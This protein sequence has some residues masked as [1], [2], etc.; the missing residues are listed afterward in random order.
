MSAPPSDS[1][2]PLSSCLELLGCYTPPLNPFQVTPDASVA[3][4]KLPDPSTGDQLAV[5]RASEALSDQVMMNLG[6][7]TRLS[8]HTFLFPAC[9]IS[10]SVQRLMALAYQ[11]L[12]EA[13]ASTDQW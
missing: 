6:P 3:L 1:L 9:H 13:L 7:E 11:T 5:L 2:Q 10:K 8:Q 12:Q 4:P